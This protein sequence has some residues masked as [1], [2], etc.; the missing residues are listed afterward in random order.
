MKRILLLALAMMV[1]TVGSLSA[2][3]KGDRFWGGQIGILVQTQ[4]GDTSHASFNVAPEAGY[5]VA[6]N[7]R[8]GG[9]LSYSSTLKGERTNLFTFGPRMAYYVR[10]V[11]KLYLAPEISFYGAFG[12]TGG[13]SSAGVGVDVDVI[14]LEYRISQRM[15]LSL[16]LVEAQYLYFGDKNHISL[17]MLGSTQIGFRCYF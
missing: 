14:S 17:N 11:D 2:Q 4:T 12:A 3:E 6:Q 1:A 16:K 9:F 15:G 5:F 10:L 8:I 13:Q 7:F